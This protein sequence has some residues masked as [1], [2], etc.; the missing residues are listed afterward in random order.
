MIPQLDASALADTSLLSS[1][2]T[3]TPREKLEEAARAFEAYILKML[4]TQMGKSVESGGLFS[5]S[6]DD[7]YRAL[8]EDALTQRAAESGSFGLARQMLDAWD[9]RR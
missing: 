7:T 2:S 9:G 6:S 3:P 4:M 5:S 8:L 1:A